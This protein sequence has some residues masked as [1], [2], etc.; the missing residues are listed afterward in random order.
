MSAAILQLNLELD[1]SATEWKRTAALFAPQFAE[2]PGL[3]W[4]IWTLD[5][6][7]G[8]AGE[9]YLFRD[10]AALDAFLTSPLVDRLRAAPFLRDL[11]VRRF[12]VMEE[13]TAVTRGPVPPSA[14]APPAGG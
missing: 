1:I 7:A 6:E 11:S 3:L 10:D 4:K 13:V 9:I 8:V 12:A 2:V 14:P 5:E